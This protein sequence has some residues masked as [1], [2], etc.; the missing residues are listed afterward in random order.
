MVEAV[1]EGEADVGVFFVDDAVVLRG[2]KGADE[3]EAVG[4]VGGDL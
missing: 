4:R 1:V 2:V 3:V